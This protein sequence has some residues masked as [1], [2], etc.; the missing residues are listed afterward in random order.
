M[1]KLPDKSRNT[2][3]LRY[4]EK[5][6]YED[7]GRSMDMKLEAVRKSLFR[8]KQKLKQCIEVRSNLEKLI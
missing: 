8:V 5:M 6:G 1:A 3:F 2:I 7:I 4:M